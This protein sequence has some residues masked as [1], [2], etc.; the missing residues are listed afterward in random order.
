MQC[1]LN[2][3]DAK[4]TKRQQAY[5]KN[6]KKRYVYTPQMVIDGRTEAVGSR[7]GQVGN[8][9][10]RAGNR[11]KLKIDVSHPNRDNLLIHIPG[12]AKH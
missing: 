3:S 5:G 12:A 2:N 10:T 9:I 6:L 8:L 1:L 7:R 4:W 11:Q